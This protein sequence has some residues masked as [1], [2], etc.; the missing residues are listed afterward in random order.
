MT[1]P[2]ELTHID[3]WGKYSV[4]SINGNQYYTIFVDDAAR[5][6]TIKFMKSKTEAVQNV[7]NYLTHLKTQEN[8]PKAIRFDNGKEFLNKE[9]ESWCAQ[10]GIDIQTTAP[11]S[12]S[13]NGVAERMNR[14]IVELARAMIN[15][16]Q[17]PQ[18]LWEHAVAHAVYVRNRAFTKPLGN[19]TP[20]ET[21]FKRRPNVS[22][23]RE[24][25]APVWILLQGQKEPPKMLPKSHR[26]AYVGYDD[27]SKSVLYYNA[28]TRKI[29]KSRNYRFLTLQKQNSPPE[30]IEVAPDLPREGEIPEGSTRISG[31]LISPGTGDKR[32]REDDYLEPRKT[33]GNRPNYSY[34]DDPYPDE[35]DDILTSEDQFANTAI[36]AGDELHSLAEAQRSP[37]WPEWEKAIKSE[38]N[39]LQEMGTWR[40]VDK[41]PDA[42]PIANKWT[43]VKKRNKAG[44]II[45]YKARLVAKGC[46]QR[47]GHD[48]VE[49]FSPVV[50]METIR[51]ILALIPIDQ[52]KI[53]QM[54]IKG[55]Y[56]NGI[57]QEKVYMRQP[58]GYEDGTDQVCVLVKT[59]YGLKQS[60]REWNKEFDNKMKSFGFQCLKSDPCVY[61]RHDADGISI[62]TVWVDDLLLFASSDKLMQ[63]MKDEI[64]SQ[65]E[66]TDMGNPSKIVGIE[67]TQTDDSNSITITQQKYIEAILEREHMESANPV[68]TPLD[69]NMK[70]GPN[71]DGNKGS[72]SNSF[73]K[74]L[75]ELQF[76][77]NATRPDIAHAIN[78][79]AA[80]TANP[81][82]QHTGALK[83][84]LRYL[85]G[86]KSYGITYTNSPE[87]T[88]NNPNIFS[89]YADAAFANQ[90]DC[91]STSGYVFMAA[92]GAITWRSKKQTTVALSS[93]EAEYIALAE[94][95]R[96]ACWLRN[97]YSELGYP[98][99]QP[100]LIRGDNN[101]SI[102]M[103]R[104]PQFHQRSKH[105]A[106]RWHLIRDLVNDGILTIDEC[107]DPEQTADVLT[108]PLTRFKHNKHITEMG[109]V[110][111]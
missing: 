42:I 71:P 23:L 22:H 99:K 41:P 27:G 34:L 51:A 104:N 12:P 93:T 107:R 21:W 94:A 81:S 49:T 83:R 16:H 4:T 31:D 70:I 109:M 88:N 110:S 10:Q 3:V 75:G 46:A 67:I 43:F 101:G 82:P 59:I 39:Q 28:E 65:W 35:E 37:D 54:D 79:L 56:L 6:T 50:R 9:L 97:L 20:Y 15:E 69:P 87:N 5:F 111:T 95:A 64:H 36:I 53:Q 86:T 80:Y 29:L 24:F 105:I 96:E 106:I 100:T 103:A 11:Y 72:R 68:G 78:R 108:K 2:G 47:P 91:K 85:A 57:L 7:K 66:A 26:R 55:A 58:E 13:Q 48:Y 98:Q 8:L 33:R 17:L 60:G 52:L 14:T 74:H 45:K 18:F 32:K 38:L 1:K 89:G 77:A 76:L 102:A 73:A 84:I 19:K 61:I 30:E 92:G 63:Q 90:D 40:M 44:E 62:I 25:G